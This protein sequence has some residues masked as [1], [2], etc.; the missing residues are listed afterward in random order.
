MARAQ[1]Q[2]SDV[3]YFLAVARAARLAKAARALGVEHT[4]VG[5]R[6]EL[7]EST[8]G[9]P[10][11]DRTAGGYLL[12]RAGRRVLAQ[13]ELMEHAALQFERRAQESR[14]A[15]EGRVRLAMTES[16]AVTWLMPRLGELQQRHPKLELVVLTGNAQTD[17]S[18]G[19]AELAVRTP[20]P[21]QRALA[22]VKL[23]VSDFALYASTKVAAKLLPHQLDAEAASLGEVPLMAYT[24]DFDFLQ[25]APWFQRLLASSNTALTTN[26]TLS[27]LVAVRA[28][29]GVGVL[30][31]FAVRRERDLVR[32][33][34]REVSRHDAWLVTHPDFRRDVRVRAV[35][36]FLKSIAPDLA[37][38]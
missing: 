28:H 14:Q 27:L 37:Q 29:V 13:A 36:T 17:L 5:R 23:G 4:T 9:S 38:R 18:R 8:L 20:R 12:T 30:P 2:W 26:S 10:L 7:L 22:A 32:V 11:F 19:E 33:A 35:A 25:S 6:I 15:V 1:L 31:E 21:Q 16:F 34:R 24:P 3:R